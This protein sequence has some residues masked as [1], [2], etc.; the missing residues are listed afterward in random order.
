MSD[1]DNENGGGGETQ[2]S[3]AG[4]AAPAGGGRAPLTLKPR[5]GG[6]VPAGTVRQNFS[7]GRSKTVVVETK[8]RRAP[9]PGDR[10]RP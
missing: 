7:H 4:S 1:G 8:R 2:G 3:G 6:A 10:P 9:E 5:G